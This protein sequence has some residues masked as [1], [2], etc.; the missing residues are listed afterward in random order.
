[1]NNRQFATTQWT[2]VW[3]A[4]SENVSEG[5]PALGEIVHRYWMPLY[6]FARHQGL[7]SEDAE[8]ATQE[9]LAQIIAGDLLAKADPAKGK[10]RTFLL[11]AWKRFLIDDYRKLKSQ[12]RGGG[13]THLT[14]DL[15]DCEMK[16]KDSAMQ[17]SDAERSFMY[18]WANSVLEEARRR[19][20][21]EYE[22][23]GKKA[24]CDSLLPKLTMPVNNEDYAAQSRALSMSPTAV[25][26]ALHRLRQRFGEILRE[27]VLETIDDP[28][29][30]DQ[31]ISD[32][33]AAVRSQN[34]I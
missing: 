8:D 16:L 27:I 34:A 31:E 25:K 29:D 26:V 12:K 15:R 21:S 9:F 17:E 19:L 14:F 28:S 4:A 13:R 20:L 6:A 3:R 23:R 1:M 24:I 18:I 22:S 2:L 5:R 11:T 33:L 32:L 30:I 10:F 7:S